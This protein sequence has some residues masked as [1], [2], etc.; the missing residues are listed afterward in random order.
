MA[1]A[2]VYGD[3]SN[4]RNAYLAFVKWLQENSKYRMTDP[5]RQIVH[6]GPW[7]E[8][9][10]DQYVGWPKS[11]EASGAFDWGQVFKF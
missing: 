10:P 2:M 3:F 11:A 7:N 6:R 4:I 8:A 9:D 5:M 1:C